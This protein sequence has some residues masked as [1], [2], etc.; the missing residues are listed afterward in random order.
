MPGTHVG[1]LCK[2][3]LG[4]LLT[5]HTVRKRKVQRAGMGEVAVPAF[6]PRAGTL[7]HAAWPQLCSKKPSYTA[8]MSYGN[9]S[10][11]K[12]IVSETLQ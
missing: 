10:F 3:A 7:A 4:V 12:Y 9:S 5:P 1:A 11:Q 2:V 8:V 6:S